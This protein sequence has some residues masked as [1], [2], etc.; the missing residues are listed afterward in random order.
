MS[1][2]KRY[3]SKWLCGLLLLQG[4]C[5]LPAAAEGHSFRP[6]TEWKDTNGNTINAHGGGVLWHEGMYYWFGEHRDNGSFT[7]QVGVRCYSSA[8]LHTWQDEGVALAVSGKKHSPITR[9][10]IIERPKVIY[11]ERTGKFVMY[12]HLE[13]KGKGYAAAQTGVAVADR[14][15]GPYELLK[16]G[17]VNARQWPLNLTEAQRNDPAKA[18]DFKEWWTPEWRSA[19]ED[20]LFV[21]RDFKG[22]Q[23]SRDMTLF[24]DDDGT[25]YH[26]YSSEDNLTLHIAELTD[27][28]LDYTGR[29]VRID[30]AGHNEAPAVFK[31]KGK[32]YMITSGC[33]GWT[34]NEARLL[35]AD[36]MLGEW[37]RLPNPC[38]GKG[39][40]RTF[41]SQSTFVLPVQGKEDAFIF[42][43]DRW[44]PDSL[45]D[46]RYVWLPIQF[47]HELPVLKWYD[48]WD[49][50]LFDSFMPDN[51]P[52]PQHSDDY[53]LV[54]HDEFD[55]DGAPNP[56]I[57]KHEQGF[58]RNHEDQWY[59]PEAATCQ[60]GVL[61]ITA[62]RVSRP[63][64]HYAADSNDWRTNRD[65]VRYTSASI[66][67]HGT[68]EFQYG[69]IEV[70][71][72]IP[73]ASGAWPAIWTLG[74]DMPWPSC[75]EIDMMEYYQVN[76][77]P[78]IL[79]NAAWGSDRPYE[80][81]WDSSRTPF[82][83][84]TDRNPH[85]ADQFHVWRMD[86]D[87][88]AIRLYLDDELLNEILLKDTY[89]GQLAGPHTNGFMQPHYIL[90][91]LAL[92]GDNGGPI[93]DTALPLVYEVD[94]V[95][96]YQKP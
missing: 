24:V 78:H 79:A 9:G 16:T 55:H 43:A 75:G 95:R 18:K 4:M 2:N 63:N 29:Y 21:R 19:V 83:H 71:A 91:N 26:V 39:A 1:M 35:V 68:W 42:M 66:N 27:D 65:S 3:L 77:Q 62:R 10:C 41:D 94:Y 59:E 30:P 33:T 6:G 80:A 74:T 5:C 90:L 46:S 53:K 7:S 93:D 58:V 32:Y 34:P 82:T 84:F 44:N 8:D 15:T 81:V 92:G 23:M 12:F 87:E 37:T 96:M 31:R 57:W 48:A 25:A 11:N 36:S 50:F 70:R 54:W 52:A 61:R 88:K 40:G 72:K 20:G 69:R 45:R 56:A 60:D 89:N 38:Q 13:L 86:W 17:R 67:T 51:Q 76:G 49:V 14:P 64:P 22:G 28:Y 73:T 85:W 47:E